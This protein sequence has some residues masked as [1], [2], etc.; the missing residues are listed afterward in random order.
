MKVVIRMVGIA[1]L[2]FSIPLTILFSSAGAVT[3]GYILMTL[4]FVFQGIF[5]FWNYF[6]KR[7]RD[8]LSLDGSS[9]QEPE[10]VKDSETS[11]GDI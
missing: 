6:E 8:R 10:P 1:C 5:E 3:V 9:P 2:V 7:N 4:A 11:E